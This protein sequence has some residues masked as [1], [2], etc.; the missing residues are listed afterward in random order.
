MFTKSITSTKTIIITARKW[1]LGQGNIF[2][3]VCQEFCLQG[4]GGIPT[5]LAGGIPA[6]LAWKGCLGPHPGGKLRDLARRG[7]PGP[8][9]GG[10]QAH[11]GGGVV[12]PSM[13]WGRPPVWTATAVG[14]MHPTG[15]HPCFTEKVAYPES[16]L[17]EYVNRKTV[18]IPQGTRIFKAGHCLKVLNVTFKLVWTMIENMTTRK[19]SSRMPTTWKPHVIHNEQ[20]WICPG[21]PAH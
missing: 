17:Y 15:I 5:C 6:C 4:G 2:K 3:S 13:H 21:V 10:L 16:A 1:S 19:N 12:Y 14:S 7:S 9:R 8:H 20:I 18:E 11:T